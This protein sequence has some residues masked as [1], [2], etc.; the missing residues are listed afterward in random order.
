M[1]FQPNINILSTIIDNPIVNVFWM[2]FMFVM[3][4][5]NVKI[6]LMAIDKIMVIMQMTSSLRAKMMVICLF[7]ACIDL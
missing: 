2:F 6:K 4:K 7:V 1:R 3:L 5:I